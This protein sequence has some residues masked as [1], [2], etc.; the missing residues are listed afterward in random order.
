MKIGILGTGHV[1]TA[2]ASGLARAGHPVKFGSR[3]PSTARV[4]KTASVSCGT[5][6]EAVAFGEA[7]ILAVPFKAWRETV[8]A[9][10]AT[11][12]AG[13]IVI[14][15]TNV[16]PPPLG[17]GS[18]TSGAEE[19]A[20]ALPGARV[21]KA[22]NHVFAGNMT[23]GRIGATKLLALVAADDASARNATIRLAADIGFDPVDA[24]PLKSARY[25]E[26][27]AL[28]LI[29]LGYGRGMGTDIGWTLAKK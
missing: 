14:D 16:F 19:I 15:T 25:M 9:I 12:F 28:Q 29:D 5:P 1:G 21:V 2:L 13:K 18:E 6:A 23:T 20:K 10:G 22:F 11:A 8:Q 26:A 27:M 17:W 24:G 4:E 7:V 3:D